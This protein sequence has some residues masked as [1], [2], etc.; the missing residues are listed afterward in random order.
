PIS[1]EAA[2]K[3]DGDAKSEIGEAKP[4]SPSANWVKIGEGALV[5]VAS[6]KP[7]PVLV[8]WSA[9]FLV[10]FVAL[11]VLLS[12]VSKAWRRAT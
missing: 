4:T 11:N 7:N 5:K 12:R 10:A 6:K 8:T 9:V 2:P 3:D 1:V